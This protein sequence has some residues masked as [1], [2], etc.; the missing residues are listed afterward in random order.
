MA[1]W[2]CLL[3]GVV[4]VPID[5]RAS[6]AFLVRVADIVSARAILVGDVVD[7]AD[8]QSPDARCGR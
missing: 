4:L 3:E 1:L 6:A 2:G 5:Y 8:V 7:A